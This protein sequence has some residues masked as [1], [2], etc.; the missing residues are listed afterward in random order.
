MKSFGGSTQVNC[1]YTP[2]PIST[3]Y[4]YKHTGTK[5]IVLRCL[6]LAEHNRNTKFIWTYLS[7][8]MYNHT[9]QTYTYLTVKQELPPH[10]G[11]HITFLECFFQTSRYSGDTCLIPPIQ[12]LNPSLILFPGGLII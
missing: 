11:Q 3:P 7:T 2:M 12:T 9:Y 10:V 5:I 6:N 8:Q 1:S 4:P